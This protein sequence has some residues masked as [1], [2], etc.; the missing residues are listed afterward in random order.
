[1]TSTSAPAARHGSLAAG[2]GFWRRWTVFTTAGEVVGFVAPS[3]AGALAFGL[4]APA[5]VS[6]A[7]LVAAGTVEGALLGLG[8]HSALV[9]A[10]PAISRRSWTVATAA[11]AAVAWAAGMLPGTLES[12]GMP[13]ALAMATWAPAS[14]VILL[15][16]GGMQWLVLRN[17]LPGASR[18]IPANI[19]AWVVAL[20]APFIGLALVPAGSPWWA[21]GMAGIASGVVMAVVVAAIT[22]WAL[23]RM[24]GPMADARRGS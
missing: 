7:A 21:W 24:I 12:L 16:I 3:L 13:F 1:M 2:G 18:W 20:P 14:V 6:S 17:H 4:G 9:R 5:L 22:G 11:A 19:V 10:L 23:V 15:S 8:E